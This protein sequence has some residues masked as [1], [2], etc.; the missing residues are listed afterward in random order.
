MDGG[1]EKAAL[2]YTEKSVQRGDMKD[3]PVIRTS[4]HLVSFWPGIQIV[5]LA[6]NSDNTGLE[7]P[8]GPLPGL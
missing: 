5:A 3:L 8:F 4:E 1:R 7:K 2:I 6:E